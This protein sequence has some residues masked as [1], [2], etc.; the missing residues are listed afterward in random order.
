MYL[1]TV[2]DSDEMGTDFDEDPFCHEA[3][4]SESSGSE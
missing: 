1:G 2:I 3:A 4:N